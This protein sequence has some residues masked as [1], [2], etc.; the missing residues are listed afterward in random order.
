VCRRWYHNAHSH[1]NF[2]FWRTKLLL[3]HQ[4]R[5]HNIGVEQQ[6]Y[7]FRKALSESQNSDLEV[8]WHEPKPKGR[9]EDT[10]RILFH[11]LL[12]VVD[13]A[14]QLASLNLLARTTAIQGLLLSFLNGLKSTPRL[15]T[16]KICQLADSSAMNAHDALTPDLHA[17][18]NIANA[19]SSLHFGA[20]SNHITHLDISGQHF[21][22]GV[23]LPRGL[24]CMETDLLN[25]L[26]SSTVGPWGVGCTLSPITRLLGLWGSESGHQ[27]VFN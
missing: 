21:G 3:G 6:G 25:G 26:S 9:I 8:S 18:Y 27:P 5:F 15:H 10:T 17:H 16:V 13:Y 2:H 1:A 12:M 19:S 4:S 22:T 20:A 24:Q 23:T 11:L 7:A 14:H